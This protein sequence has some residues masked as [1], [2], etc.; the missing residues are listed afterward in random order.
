MSANGDNV[1][2]QEQINVEVDPNSVKFFESDN[3]KSEEDRYNAMRTLKAFKDCIM[4]DDI[5]V[6]L[7]KFIIAYRELIK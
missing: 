5:N 3:S 7:K 6:D 1:Q 4:E 2:Q